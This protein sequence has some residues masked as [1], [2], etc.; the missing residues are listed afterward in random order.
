MTNT[1]EIFNKDS[2]NKTNESTNENYWTFFSNPR[3]WEIDCFLKSD[4]ANDEIH[5]S[6][7][8]WHKDKI[9]IGDKGVIRVGRDN[10][11]KAELKNK[12]K[13]RPGIY[14]IIE[15]VS[16]PEIIKD[17]SDEFYLNKSDMNKERWKVKIKI[18]KNLI[19]SPIIFDDYIKSVLNE[20]KYLIDGFQRSSMQL[21]ESEFNKIIGLTLVNKESISDKD[22]IDA[23]KLGNDLAGITILNEIYKKINIQKKDKLVKAIERGKIANEIKKYAGYKCQICEVIGNTPYTFKKK[24]GEYY[25]ETH[26]IIP[27]S[28]IENS[29]LSVEN[30]IC[31]CPNHHRQ[32]H[33]GNVDIILNS[34]LYIKY[35]I[36]NKEVTIKKIN[37]K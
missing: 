23:E 26:H 18:I 29:S 33:Y 6:I 12:P 31:V 20:D 19:D 27:V 25:I 10:R 1:Y 34:E 5:Y 4:K 13:L 35:L 16:Y 24:N 8:D 7:N 30:L 11:T 3:K 17:I 36:D 9:K 21:L 22:L 14:A 37:L 28:D 15:I 2:L 32:L